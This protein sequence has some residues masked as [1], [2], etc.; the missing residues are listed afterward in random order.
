MRSS[1]VRPRR[2]PWC[3][4]VE[5]LVDHTTVVLALDSKRLF[6]LGA[7]AVFE[8]V[9]AQSFA[10]SRKPFACLFCFPLGTLALFANE[11]LAFGFI[12]GAITN[13]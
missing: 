11:L 10:A 7:F 2:R 9:L 6:Q 1:W 12:H 13:S 8:Q 3:A 4:V 5:G